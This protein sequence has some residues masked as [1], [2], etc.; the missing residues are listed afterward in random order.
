V[1]ELLKRYRELILVAVLLVLPLG[2]FFARAKRPAERSALDRAVVWATAPLET[3]V[4]FTIT[5]ALRAWNGYLALH[6]AEERAIALSREVNALRV[7]R[8]ELLQDRAEV[9]RL[10]KLLDFAQNAPGRSYVGARVVGVE[11]SP[12]GLQLLIINRGEAD[13]V[14]R[15]KPVITAD[16]V[17]GRVH[18]ATAHSAEVLLVT[19]R[20]S[21]VAVQVDRSR[22]RAN[23]RGLGRPEMCKLD[24]ALRAED[25]AEGDLLVTSGTDGVFPRGLPVGK[26]TQLKKSGNGLFQDAMVDPA[27]NVTRVE[28]VL[29]VTTWETRTS[30]VGPAAGRQP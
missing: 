4:S 6:G 21:S 29:V 8:Q 7:E 2:V 26:V 28:E 11:L 20:S 23:V 17:V 18:T 1:L 5:G 3:A 22:T 27:V 10:R 14:T 25:M 15:M 9:E 19:D 30:E 16:G 13:G 12:S 24:Y